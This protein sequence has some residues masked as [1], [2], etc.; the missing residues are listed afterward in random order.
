MRVERTYGDPISLKTV[1]IES[2]NTKSFYFSYWMTC[3]SNIRDKKENMFDRKMTIGFKALQSKKN[4]LNT[5]ENIDMLLAFCKSIGMGFKFDEEEFL[6]TRKHMKPV[7]DH[8]QLN[9]LEKL[10]FQNFESIWRMIR[11]LEEELNHED[12]YF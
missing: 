6:L 3:I 2:I 9:T 11:S 7:Y 5:S 8:V 10:M 1:Y 4:V 12:V